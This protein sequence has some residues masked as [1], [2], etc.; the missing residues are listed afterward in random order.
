MASPRY[1]SWLGRSF[2]Y[3]C[4]QH[5]EE[6]SRIMGFH[7]IP[8]S[9]GPFFDRKNIHDSSIQI[10]LLFERSDRVL[11]L[12]EMKY[13]LTRTPNDV[14]D[15]V[16]KK[17]SALHERY[18][19]RTILKVLLTKSIPTDSVS[20]SNYFYR[21]IKADELIKIISNPSNVSIIQKS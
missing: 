18:P 10:D 8:Y 9:V 14:I 11:V 5:H 21:I 12:C 16:K 2:E 3:L 20:N 4:M 1:S 6:I 17:V 13:L 19:D 7:G 15:Q